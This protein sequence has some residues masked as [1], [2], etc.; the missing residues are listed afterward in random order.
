MS[1][2][3]IRAG[4]GDMVLHNC[5]GSGLNV[6]EHGRGEIALLGS[7]LRQVQFSSGD[8]SAE[9]DICVTDSRLAQVWLD[10]GLRGSFAAK[11]GSLLHLWNDSDSLVATVTRSRVH[12]VVGAVLTECS[13]PHDLP[14]AGQS[15][16]LD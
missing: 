6:V 15:A 5:S 8:E 14:A 9:I 12:G 4:A 3:V 2:T 11:G 1:S 13:Q 16:R 7:E 10:R